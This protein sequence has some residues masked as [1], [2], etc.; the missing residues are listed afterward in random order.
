M[1]SYEDNMFNKN[2]VHRYILGL[3][4]LLSAFLEVYLLWQNGYGNS[5]YAAAVKSMT[6]SWHNFFFV[7]FDPGGFI[8]VDKPPLAL[9]I[10]TLFAKIFGFSGFVILLPQAVAQ[11]IA[12]GLIYKLVNKTSGKVAGLIAAFVLAITPINVALA[13][14]NEVDGILVLVLV[15]AAWAFLVALETKKLRYLFLSFAII[16]FGFNTKTLEAY[17]AL[18][19][20]ELGYFLSSIAPWPKKIRNLILANI[21]LLVVSFSW[22]SVV[23]M[24]PPSNRPYVGSSQINS[25]FNLAI[26]YNGIQRITGMFRGGRRALEIPLPAA[27]E[28]PEVPLRNFNRGGFG[29][30]GGSP[31]LF[32]LFN[33]QYGSQISWLLAFALI[34]VLAIVFTQKTYFPLAD[35]QLTTSFWGVWVA[36]GVAV[37]S[38]AS[39]L[40]P[41]YT[42]IMGPAIAALV[43]IGSVWFWEEYLRNTWR[44]WLLPLA[45]AVSA[46]VQVVIL[47]Y[48]PSYSHLLT[49]VIVTG[50]VVAVLFFVTA[51]ISRIGVLQKYVSAVCLA[52]LFVL[53]LVPSVWAVY[54]TFHPLNTSMPTAGPNEVTFRLGDQSDRRPFQSI[55][56]PQGNIEA[57]NF[58]R[59]G[60]SM[61]TTANQEL[62][63]YL[64][65]N[66]GSTKFLAATLNSITASPIILATGKPV[67]ALGGF[68]GSDK[69]LS[70]SELEEDVKNNVV[71][72]FLLSQTGVANRFGDNDG[73]LLLSFPGFSDSERINDFNGFQGRGG[74]NGQ[75]SANS[76][77]SE[78]VTKTCKIVPGISSLY[79]CVGE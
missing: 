33:G 68:S 42:A 40:H 13:R 11:V 15:L 60:V 61:L 26:G 38:V 71:R 21:I 69:V 67:M 43:G 3:I 20:F 45:L 22:I 78:W 56:P 53:I 9:W 2:S 66:Q 6:E 31:G 41:Y 36:S 28:L 52:S 50:S 37:F 70:L 19:A 74:F 57:G 34:S 10:Q 55:R 32:R 47:S 39:T 14:T 65:D 1:S 62:I 54:S 49:P 44:K 63:R 12:V 72:Y 76:A 51:K 17:I 35:K 24:T 29:F 16:G 5:Y 64:E 4:L 59:F 7:S 25:E 23:D 18:P 73:D 30:N 48:T 46:I 75:G 27:I 77:L 79:D 58:G 8:S